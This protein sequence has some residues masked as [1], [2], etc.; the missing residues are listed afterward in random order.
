MKRRY[1]FLVAVLLGFTLSAS[2]QFCIPDST[3]LD[4]SGLV[5]PL[6]FD[7]INNPM[8]GIDEPACINAEYSFRWTLNIPDTVEYPG[9]PLPIPIEH[10]AVDTIGA[11]ANLPEGIGYRCHPPNCVFEAGELGCVVLEGIPTENNTPGNYSLEFTGDLK[12]KIGA[13]LPVTFPNE[14][15]FPGYYFLE[16]L[17]E[18]D[19]ICFASTDNVDDLLLDHQVF[20][21]PAGPEAHLFLDLSA[22][23][24]IQVWLYDL[25][26]TTLQVQELIGQQ[27]SN[28]LEL[29]LQGVPAGMIFYRV[30][31]PGT[32][33]VTGQFLRVNR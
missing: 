15:L 31:F 7:T 9:I 25:R 32:G 2:A 20:P 10:F 18:N 26:G 1:G 30:V 24:P 8:G 13:T 14:T 5:Y 17:A 21:N 23:Q 12:T 33:H 28:W 11:I 19:P 16:V 27:G 3:Y 22:T 4:S 6:P 29:P